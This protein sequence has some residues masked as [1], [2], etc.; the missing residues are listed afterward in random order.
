V[1]QPGIVSELAELLAGL[2]LDRHEAP[3]RLLVAVPLK[4]GMLEQA[5]ELIAE[6]PP[7]DSEETGLERHR[8]FLLEDEV[9]FVFE[10]GQSAKKLEAALARPDLWRGAAAWQDLVAGPPRIA[11]AVYAWDREAPEDGRDEN[12]LSFEATPGPGDSEGGE[13][14]AP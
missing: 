10:S 13:L 11:E 6:G 4:E 1:A 3:C 9:L 7:F 12:S 5:R 14:Y 8:V 2:C